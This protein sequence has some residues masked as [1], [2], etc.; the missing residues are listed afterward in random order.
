M[1]IKKEYLESL[2]SL[3][4]EEIKDILINILGQSGFLIN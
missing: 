4:I 1:N 3:E 2:F